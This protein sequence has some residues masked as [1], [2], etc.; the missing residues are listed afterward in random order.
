MKRTAMLAVLMMLLFSVSA[1]TLTGSVSAAPI[2]GLKGSG[3]ISD[4]YLI[5]SADDL[6]TVSSSHYLHDGAYY[7]QTSDIVFDDSSLREQMMTVHVSIAGGMVTV[8]LLTEEITET[9]GYRSPPAVWLN[10]SK[11]NLLQKDGRFADTVFSADILK[12]N[13]YVMAAGGF[14]GKTFATAVSFSDDIGDI[15]VSAPMSG[16]FMPI[17]SEDRPFSG[18][19]DGN[20]HSIAGMKVVSAGSE[21]TSAG[22]FAY[23]DSAVVIDTRIISGEGHRSYFLTYTND[24][25]EYYKGP[26]HQTDRRSY[27]GSIVGHGTAMSSIISCYSE[28]L[29]FSAVKLNV[30]DW[31][32]VQDVM[33]YGLS[34]DGTVMS[35]AGGIAG[36]GVGRI[37]DCENAGSIASLL[38]FCSY[39]T[40]SPSDLFMETGSSGDAIRPDI[41]FSFDDDVSVCN[42]A[43]G[44]IGYSDNMMLTASGNS[45]HVSAVTDISSYH[46]NEMPMPFMY[47]TPFISTERLV[48]AAGGVA[49]SLKDS[50]IS[51]VHNRGTVSSDLSEELEMF[52]VENGSAG[53]SVS[54]TIDACAGGIVGLL[55]GT[56]E[57]KNGINTG[58]VT[59]DDSASVSVQS[60]SF[61]LHAKAEGEGSYTGEIAGAADDVSHIVNCYYTER[62]E[63]RMAAGND[64]RHSATPV[65]PSEMLS[66]GI[67]EGWDFDHIWT[68]SDD[69]YLKIWMRYPMIMFD[70][71]GEFDGTAKYSVDREHMFD[72]DGT[73]HADTDRTGF[74][75]TLADDYEDSEIAIY[76]MIGDEKVVLGTDAGDNYMIPSL[77]FA[78]ASPVALY[79][80]GLVHNEPEDNGTEGPI[81]SGPA[82]GIIDDLG[83]LA[84]DDKGKLILTSMLII[85]ALG[86]IVTLRNAM[87]A[88]SILRMCAAACPKEDE[89]D[90]QAG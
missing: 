30:Y 67:L 26:S 64:G 52:A 89:N 58:A 78:G 32:P 29:V 45:G 65:G 5:S 49:G 24:S 20:G 74:A 1:V 59:A 40:F 41:P 73:L 12:D 86:I 60:V 39:S 51:D 61:D 43:G 36:F 80:G 14:N 87:S 21:D 76:T 11:K 77:A 48:S 69:G 53:H 55:S 50:I 19:Y 22:M 25:S 42:F 57:I 31:Y 54:Q 17:G 7:R 35:Y 71:S 34:Y 4:P 47:D 81:G 18:V 13:N 16:N 6:R 23:A 70:V 56:S 66:P 75:V 44:I 37:H 83:T 79:I 82:E 8:S 72:E 2:D 9:A 27:I 62:P 90:E 84:S 46:F 3:T 38:S 10:G 63:N 85:I 28:A 15:S 88:R 33:D 68:V